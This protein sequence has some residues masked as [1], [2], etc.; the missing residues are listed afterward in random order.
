VRAD[1]ARLRRWGSSAIPLR[2]GCEC[3]NNGLSPS[4]RQGPHQATS[5]LGDP[6][7]KDASLGHPGRNSREFILFAERMRESCTIAAERPWTKGNAVLTVVCMMALQSRCCR[8]TS[9]PPQNA[10]PQSFNTLAHSLRLSVTSI[11]SRRS[12]LHQLCPLEHQVAMLMHIMRVLAVVSRIMGRIV[13]Q[14]SALEA[15]FKVLLPNFGVSVQC[16]RTPVCF[17]PRQVD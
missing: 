12:V 8:P 17:H 5:G 13:S 11:R 9:G 6:S 1:A 15:S 16:R 14:K 7:G 4:T 3:T 10:P 2:I